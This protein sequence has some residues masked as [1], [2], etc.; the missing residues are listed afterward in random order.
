MQ[1]N[2]AQSI[3]GFLKTPN[4]NPFGFTF[5][6]SVFV[7]KNQIKIVSLFFAVFVV[8]LFVGVRI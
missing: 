3:Y 1:Q 4:P 8:V 6:C 5:D 2:V 7:I